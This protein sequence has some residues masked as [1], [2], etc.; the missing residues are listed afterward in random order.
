MM[1]KMILGLFIHSTLVLSFTAASFAQE[2]IHTWTVD[3]SMGPV[4]FYIEKQENPTPEVK[5]QMRAI[6][7][8]MHTQDNDAKLSQGDA[9]LRKKRFESYGHQILDL[10][11]Q[12][13]LFAIYRK[14]SGTDSQPVF[15]GGSY[16]QIEDNLVDPTATAKVVRNRTA[17]HDVSL[18]TDQEKQMYLKNLMEALSSKTNFPMADKLVVFVQ[19]E[20]PFVGALKYF[21]FTDSDYSTEHANP[22]FIGAYEKPI[23]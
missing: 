23:A 21:G 9:A 5:E 12:F 15:I 1:K 20:S 13:S 17:A 3:G 10:A 7:I 22:A 8:K 14:E 6:S 19:Y 18:L 11:E 2:I 4:E 16:Y